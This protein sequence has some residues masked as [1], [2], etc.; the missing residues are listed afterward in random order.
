MAVIRGKWYSLKHFTYHHP[1]PKKIFALV[2][3]SLLGHIWL[4]IQCMWSLDHFCYYYCF[5]IH[6]MTWILPCI[7]ISSTHIYYPILPSSLVR[8]E[9]GDRFYIL[10]LISQGKGGSREVYC[11]ASLG[12]DSQQILWDVC[13]HYLSF[14]HLIF[15][16]NTVRITSLPFYKGGY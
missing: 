14:F 6:N 7:F 12:A 13:F 11:W 4:L 5:C 2:E 3:T 10:T 8:W 15:S 1:L 9:V 16:N